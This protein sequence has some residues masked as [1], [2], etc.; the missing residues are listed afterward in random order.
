MPSIQLPPLELLVPADAV[1][2]IRDW[3]PFADS[4]TLE[5]EVVAA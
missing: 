5:D 4:R 1:D 3:H 2:Y